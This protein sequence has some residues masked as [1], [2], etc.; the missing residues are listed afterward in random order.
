MYETWHGSS[1]IRILAATIQAK[2]HGEKVAALYG[3]NEKLHELINELI[4]AF[5]RTGSD[6]GPTSRKQTTFEVGYEC[7]HGIKSHT[8][9]PK[10]LRRIV[11]RSYFAGATTALNPAPVYVTGAAKRISDH[12]YQFTRREG[13]RAVGSMPLDFFRAR[14][15]QFSKQADLN[16]YFCK[17][18]QVGPF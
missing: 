13:E 10:Y 17:A 11:E 16:H 4:H 14:L 18:V 7:L 8:S 5:E 3:M 9:L 12:R 15:E 6:S 2:A 1:V